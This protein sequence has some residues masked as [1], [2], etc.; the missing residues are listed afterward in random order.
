MDHILSL[1]TFTPALAALILG[2]FLRGDTPAAQRNAK[3][4]ALAAS[5]ITFAASLT[6]LW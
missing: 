4:F 3:I 2:L 1:I 5:V 6:L